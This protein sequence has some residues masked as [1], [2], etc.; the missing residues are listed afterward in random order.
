MCKLPLEILYGTW[1]HEVGSLLIAAHVLLQHVGMVFKNFSVDEI[2][3]LQ[4]MYM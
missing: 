2:P 1:E 3:D 4:L